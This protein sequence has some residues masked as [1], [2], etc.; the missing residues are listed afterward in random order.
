MTAH[1][2]TEHELDALPQADAAC[3]GDSLD[4]EALRREVGISD[5]E[6]ERANDVQAG[7]WMAY[8]FRERARLSQKELADRLGVTQA[9]VS[10]IE[11]GEGRDGV[12][13]ALLRKIAR[14]CGVDWR[15]EQVMFG[16]DARRKRGGLRARKLPASSQPAQET[17]PVPLDYSDIQRFVEH[18]LAG[19]QFDM[20]SLGELLKRRG[21]MPATTFPK[22]VRQVF[23]DKLN[24][25]DLE[26]TLFMPVKRG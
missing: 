10:K 15:P 22:S 2:M 14:V 9:R 21:E 20:V 17:G 8:M 23:L 11:R 1:G 18:Q 16:A 26:Q 19:D 24:V 13:F 3:G 4:I 12:S 5:A 25:S 7:A 6:W